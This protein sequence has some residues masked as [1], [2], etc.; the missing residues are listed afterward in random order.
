M[1]LEGIGANGR[2]QST[3]NLG[4]PVMTARGAKTLPPLTVNSRPAAVSSAPI[5]PPPPPP[6]LP[7]APQ[8]NMGDMGF[9]GG[10]SFTSTLAPA[11]PPP[12]PTEEE[13]L[14]GDATYK[15]QL[16]ALIAALDNYGT[17]QTR[18]RG[19]YDTDFIN[20]LDTLGFR[21]SD[22]SADTADDRVWQ[23]NDLNTSF[24]RGTQSI[25]NDFAGRGM[26]QSTG[27]A[28]A[29]DDLMRSLMDQVASMD[30]GRQRFTD[31]LGAQRSAFEA[32]NKVGQQDARN[33]ALQ[34]RALQYMS[35]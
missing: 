6:P 30:T 26:L 22:R 1:A 17:E 12:M 33:S 3:K 34:R 8:I 16:A 9:G 27:F 25:Q 19:N 28:R 23:N 31:D 10:D 11:A 32:Q 18:Q 2:V 20:A 13:F 4:G 35:V 5:A 24:G 29:Q 7:P 14:A 21:D 15:D